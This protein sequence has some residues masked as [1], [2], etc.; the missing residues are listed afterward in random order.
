MNEK[1]DIYNFGV[2]LLEL[3]TG[4][5]LNVVPFGDDLGIVRWVQNHI[6]I[7]INIVLD[8]CITN[9]HREE[10]MLMLR[11]ALL[12][13]STLPI[14]R[15]FMREFVEMMLLCSPNEE[16]GKAIAATFSPHLK[17]NL[18]AF[19]SNSTY[20]FSYAHNSIYPFQGSDLGLDV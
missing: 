12:C 4:K 13:T 11:V 15:P 16:T 7:D 10:M 6:N 1:S 3:V 2:F 14:N 17:R 19:T 8:S 18:S 9:L 20:A 5:K